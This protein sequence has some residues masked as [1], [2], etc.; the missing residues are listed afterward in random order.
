[1][2]FTFVI[3]HYN[4]ID[5]TINCINTIKKLKVN[6]ND[7]VKII[8]IDNKSTNH[9]GTELASKYSNDKQIKV[10]LLNKN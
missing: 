4:N 2:K 10:I 8:L 7:E 5:D 9:T 3:L 6:K 1:M